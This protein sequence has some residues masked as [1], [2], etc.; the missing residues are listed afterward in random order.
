VPT[1]LDNVTRPIFFV[2]GRHDGAWPMHMREVE[3]RPQFPSFVNEEY[4]LFYA[5]SAPGA[6]RL[7]ASMRGGEA[8][9]GVKC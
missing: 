9:K 3:R 7:I 8:V 1:K 4:G 2:I 6:P 5:E